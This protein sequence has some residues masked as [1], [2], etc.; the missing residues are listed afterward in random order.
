MIV[1]ECLLIENIFVEIRESKIRVYWL[2]PCQPLRETGHVVESSAKSDKQCALDQ[3]I[4]NGGNLLEGESTEKQVTR[5]EQMVPIR[6]TACT[7]RFIRLFARYDRL[8]WHQPLVFPVCQSFPHN[9]A[10]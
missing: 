10:D 9:A 3:R 8:I 7:N 5:Q 4:A 2:F 1:I 6:P